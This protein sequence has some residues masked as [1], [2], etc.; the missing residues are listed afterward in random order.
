MKARTEHR[1][2]VFEIWRLNVPV[3]ALE[4]FSWSRCAHGGVHTQKSYCSCKFQQRQSCVKHYW[5]EYVWMGDERHCAADLS[6]N[7]CNN[8]DGHDIF[9]LR[10]WTFRYFPS[11]IIITFWA[12]DHNLYSWHESTSINLNFN[13]I[14]F[15]CLGKFQ[16]YKIYFEWLCTYIFR[17][18][19]CCCAHCSSSAQQ[20]KKLDWNIPIQYSVWCGKNVPATPLPL[21]PTYSHNRAF[22]FHVDSKYNWMNANKSNVCKMN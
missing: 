20:K 16:V 11:I 3:M 8:D 6:V 10:T 13:C 9:S 15:L 2:P 12:D 18:F 21:Y 17:L 1:E 5:E 4:V 19:G 7:V 14:R 22:P